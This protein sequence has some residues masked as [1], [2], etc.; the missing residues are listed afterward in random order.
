[1]IKPRTLLVWPNPFHA[2]D[3]EGHP[4][5]VLSYEPTGDGVKTFDSRR[6]I[7]ATLQSKILEKA[8][9]GTA[10]Q[11]MQR[12]WFEFTEEVVEVPE[13]AYYKHAIARGEIFAADEA[14]A[15]RCGIVQGFVEPAELLERAR[16]EAVDAYE[17][18]PPH[19]DL[20]GLAPD[21]L[22]KFSFGPMK[23][24]TEKRKLRDAEAKKA[25]E[26]QVKRDEDARLAEAK[27]V[28]DRAAARA[29]RDEET[30]KAAA[31]E[32]AAAEEATKNEAVAKKVAEEAKAKAS[33][34]NTPPS[35][36][37][38]RGNRLKGDS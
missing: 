30:A 12:T 8:V 15:R 19:E 34:T 37:P 20:D 3:H 38:Q 1:M 6:F 32:K 36:A 29:K 27:G 4:A 5:G 14:T 16:K 26:G 17:R 2:L 35:D 18:N 21:E 24:A 7:G 22:V 10:Q 23:E 13:S 25:E 9:E 33:A 31:A 28:A 11:T